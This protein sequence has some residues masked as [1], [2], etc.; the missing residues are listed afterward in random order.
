MRIRSNERR[1]RWAALGA[2]L[3][4]VV[5]LLGYYFAHKPVAPQTAVALALV[6]F[7]AAI[8][9]GIV[10][11]AGG[12]GH[13]LAP[14]V[15][16]HP[17]ANLAVQAALGL[18]LLALA[19][20]CV[21]A[22]GALTPVVGWIALGAGLVALA[23]HVRE[24]STQWSA[25]TVLL[26]QSTRFEHAVALL[27]IVL[28]GASLLQACAP[29]IQF[30]AL[31]YHLL[32]PKIFAAQRSMALVPDLPYW[33]NPLGA[34]LLFTWTMLLTRPQAAA[35]FGWMV[36]ILACAGVLGLGAS[37]HRTAGWI[38]VAALLAGESVS[39]ALGWAYVDW[40]AC[41]FGVALLGV[42]A[43]SPSARPR[44]VVLAGLLVGF[45]FGTKYTAGVLVFSGAAAMCVAWPEAR[46]PRTLLTFGL[47]ALLSS[48]PWLVKNWVAAG[49][50]L[51]PYV[52]ASAWISGARQAALHA[53]VSGGDIWRS[54]L[55]PFT[56]TFLGHEKAPGFSA[57]IGPL[58]LGLSFG[59][60]LVPRRLSRMTA[61][62]AAFVAAGWLVWAIAA[63]LSSLLIQT[64]LYYALLPAWALL[65]GF[66]AVGIS[67]IRLG[68]VRLRRLLQGVVGITLVFSAIHAGVNMLRERTFA[69][70]VGLETEGD[71]RLRNLG[72]VE[73]AM[74][75]IQ[76]LPEGRRVLLLWEARG[77]QCWPRCS[78]D[79]W[80]DRWYLARRALPSGQAILD[81][82]AADGYTDV[83]VNL[84][85]MKFVRAQDERYLEEDWT[86]LEELLA[87]LPESESFGEG[88]R[89]YRLP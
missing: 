82:W 31:V 30:D 27:L 81:S 9:A 29:P 52:G 8:A 22:I 13:R 43:G 65:A 12:V 77:F 15:H 74:Q 75:G 61:M 5:T 56:A 20:L 76:T 69:P 86:V 25:L 11:L 88:Y 89:L 7:D 67:R 50:P 17:L 6:L 84:D 16:P 64:R 72:A 85:G 49:T 24:W 78:P 19:V 39:A 37:A 44:T 60:L 1:A 36:G 2:L 55:L 18:G 47:T 62:V 32:L 70:V 28:A 48:L 42:L 45:G 80:I 83:L 53:S 79:A 14:A 71:F 3:A 40:F 38:A 34:E 68:K 54:V 23:R 33:G 66:G 87:T 35:L 26:R 51:F 73:L 58:L 4:A 46:R 59:A 57:S 21:G 41:L 63:L 10:L